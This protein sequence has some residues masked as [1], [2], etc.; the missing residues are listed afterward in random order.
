MYKQSNGI[1][2][3][4]PFCKSEEVTHSTQWAGDL[5]SGKDVNLINWKCDNNH[6]WFYRLIG[7]GTHEPGTSSPEFDLN[8]AK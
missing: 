4:C 5:Y 3:K 8:K 2:L 1:D 7:Y 6:K